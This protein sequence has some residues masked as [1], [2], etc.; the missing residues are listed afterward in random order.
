MCEKELM[1]S[2]LRILLQRGTIDEEVFNKSVK[3]IKDES[4]KGRYSL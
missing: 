3:K 1:V 2:V 4:N